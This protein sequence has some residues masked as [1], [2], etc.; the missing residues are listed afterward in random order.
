MRIRGIG[1]IVAV[2]VV[3]ALVACT[4]TASRPRATTHANAPAR[5]ISRRCDTAPSLH[6]TCYWL[7][8]PERRDLVDA[9]RIKLWVAVIREPGAPA[10]AVPFIQLSGGPGDAESSPFTMPNGVVFV[11][12]PGVL[13]VVDQRGTGRS[14]PRLDCAALSSAP[15]STLPWSTRL[16]RQ[17]AEISR[18]WDQYRASGIDVNGYNV[19]EDA[20]D[21]VDLRHALGYPHWVL[22]SI[23]YGGLLAQQVLRA[24]PNGVTGVLMDSPMTW[25]HQGPASLLQRARDGVRRLGAACAAVPSCIAKTPDMQ[26]SLDRASTWLDAHPQHV[27]VTIG[28]RAQTLVITGQ[29]LHAAVFAAEYGGDRIPLIPPI[30]AAVARGDPTSFDAVASQFADYV[31]DGAEGVHGI[32]S[33][34]DM[35]NRYTAADQQVLRNPAE[36]GTLL[37]DSGLANCEAWQ[38]KGI[39]QALQPAKATTPVLIVEGGLDA[40]A[41]PRFATEISAHL[42]HTTIL[43]VPAWG[44]GPAF[45]NPCTSKIAADFTHDPSHLA[46]T[47]CVNKLPKPFTN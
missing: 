12:K 5:L 10:N 26:A 23:S 18:C 24:D 1:R 19:L 4:S 37:L 40:I 7:D 31:G 17:R 44:H 43:V 14:Q 32:G 29:E 38:T 46:N 21:I 20:A 33:C 47:T 9:R 36:Y 2:P 11:G 39:P 25:S 27:Q 45:G 30:L 42:P 35:Q 41:P 8:V 3:L 34:A 6:A 16:A 28:D 13:V 15:A 22:G